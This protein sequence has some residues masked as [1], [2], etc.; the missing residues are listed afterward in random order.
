[1]RIFSFF[2]INLVFTTD[3]EKMI[4]D[5]EKDNKFGMMDPNMMDIGES[6][7]KKKYFYIYFVYFFI[8][9]Y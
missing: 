2:L 1:M 7:F 6:N 8:Y 5:K 9:I 3:N 4:K